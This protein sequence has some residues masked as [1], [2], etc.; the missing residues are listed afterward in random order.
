VLDF[1]FPVAVTL[2]RNAAPGRFD[3]AIDL[4]VGELKAKLKSAKY[5]A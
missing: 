2:V 3:P 5:V 4:L 1:A